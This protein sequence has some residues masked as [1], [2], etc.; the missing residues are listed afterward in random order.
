M[1]RTMT[2][3]PTWLVRLVEIYSNETGALVARY[4]L[5]T[6]DLAELQRLWGQRA[7]EPMLELFE[8]TEAQRPFLESLLGRPLELSKDAYFLGT[9]CSDPDAMRRDGGFMGKL[10]PP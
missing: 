9:R 3:Q 6:V 1:G 10:A 2:P 8:V 7:D 5:P 4:E